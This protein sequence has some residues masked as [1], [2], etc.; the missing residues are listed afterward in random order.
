MTLDEARRFV[1]QSAVRCLRAAHAHPP[2]LVAMFWAT[3][4]VSLDD[5]DARLAAEHRGVLNS[6]GAAGYDGVIA[7]ELDG[8]ASA[9]GL[10]EGAVTN[11]ELIAQAVADREDSQED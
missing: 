5:H 11:L 3:P 6:V 9:T 1:G 8:I 2:E 10:Y 4:A 7:D